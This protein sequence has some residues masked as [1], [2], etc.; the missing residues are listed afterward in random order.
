[1]SSAIEAMGMSLPGSA[2]HPAVST[3]KSKD[4]RAAGKAV[5]KLLEKVNVKLHW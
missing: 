4:S 2:S 3:N 1:M 5:Y